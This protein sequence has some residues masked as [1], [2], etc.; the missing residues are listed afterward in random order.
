MRYYEIEPM[1]R[2]VGWGIRG[3]PFNGLGCT[4]GARCSI[5]SSDPRVSARA[6]NADRYGP[7]FR[8]ERRE[9][10]RVV[11]AGETSGDGS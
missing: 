11:D 6:Y 4:Y 7:D 9:R 8:C 10:A 5:N 2:P 3:C 1:C